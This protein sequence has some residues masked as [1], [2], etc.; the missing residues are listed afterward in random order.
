MKDLTCCEYMQMAS[1]LGSSLAKA[2]NSLGS[3]IMTTLKGQSSAAATADLEA[4]QPSTNSTSN[5]TTGPNETAKGTTIAAPEPEQ[6]SRQLYDTQV[7]PLQISF[8]QLAYQPLL[9]CIPCSQN[10]AGTATDLLQ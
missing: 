5:Q 3:Q 10:S 7:H 8:L 4:S 6:T 1:D 9:L 2:T